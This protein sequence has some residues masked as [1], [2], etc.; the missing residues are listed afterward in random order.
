MA[1]RLVIHRWTDG[2][3]GELVAGGLEDGEQGGVRGM[4]VPASILAML[5]WGMPT[6][7][8]RSC[9]VM[10]A[11]LRAHRTPRWMAFAFIQRIYH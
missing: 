7:C 9:C 6:A 3:N 8:A 1:N 2:L 10:P 4:T 5:G 11:R